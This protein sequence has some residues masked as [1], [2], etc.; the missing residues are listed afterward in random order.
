MS[1]HRAIA[2]TAKGV[3]EQINLPT[4][5]PAREEVL[6]Q[7]AYAALAP[8][9][10]YQL[11]RGFAV[12]GYPHVLGLASAGFVKAVGEGVT[13]LREGDK[14]CAYNLHVNSNKA[15]QEYALVS[16]ILVAKLPNEYSLAEAASLPDNYTTAMFTLF[17]APS[18][19]LPLPSSFPAPSPPPSQPILVYGAGASSGQYTLQILKLAGYTQIYAT[20]SPRH[21]AYLRELGATHCFD[22]R[23]PHLAQDILQTSGG[24]KMTVVIDTIAAKPSIEAYS[25]VLGKDTRLAVLIPIKKGAAVTNNADDDMSTVVE[26][27]LQQVVGE[28]TIV[29]IYTFKLQEDPVAATFMAKI[30]PQLLESNSIHPN[31]IRLFQASEGPLLERV[32]TALDLLRNNKISGEK[33]VIELKWQ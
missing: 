27:W 2:A 18:L 6:I 16:R 28:A 21:H 4:P 22:Y 30:L 19:A 9:D 24:A 11:D 29:P 12:A 23:S 7:V 17:G 13:D 31:P 26:P 1:S 15:L 32:D 8:F 10:A 5:T 33:V 3:L 20:A 14:V 25:G